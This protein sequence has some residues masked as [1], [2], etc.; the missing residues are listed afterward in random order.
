MFGPVDRN[1]RPDHDAHAV[2]SASHPLV[3]RIV[4]EPHI[5]TTQF[6]RPPKQRLDVFVVVRAPPAER[7]LRVN[8]DTAQKSRLSVQQDMLAVCLDSSEADFI[9]KFVISRGERDAVEFGTIRRPQLQAI[10]G[11]PDQSFSTGIQLRGYR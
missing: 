8:G 2:S 9:F 6:V 11:N 4:G 5:I 7:R 1:L 10:C 3:V